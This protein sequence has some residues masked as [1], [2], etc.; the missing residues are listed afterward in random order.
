VKPQQQAAF[1][2]MCRRDPMF[3]RNNLIVD[4]PNGPDK[5]GKFMSP[6]QR[7]NFA[8]LD[9]AL[10][11]LT[12]IGPQPQI[13]RFWDQRS[14]GYSKT[15]D[16]AT[17]VLY[18]LT[19]CPKKLDAVVAAEDRDQALLIREQMLKV[20]QYNDWLYKYIDVQRNRIKNKTTDAT[21]N[22]LSRDTASSFGLT[23]ELVI[24]DEFTHWTQEDFWSS[25]FSSFNK[26]AARGGTLI[27]ACNAGWGTDWK[28]KV[29]ELARTSPLWHYSAPSGWAPWYRDID[30]DEQRAGLTASEFGRLWMNEWQASSGE[31]VTLEEADAC[32]NPMLVKL[33]KTPVDGHSFVASLDY[34]EKKDRCVGV[35]SDLY[36]GVIRIHRMD[37][38][39]PE[40]MPDKRVKA[41]WVYEWMKT[42]QQAFGGTNGNVTFILDPYQTLHFIQ[43][44]ETE[45][46]I[47]R[48]EFASGN[49]N[50]EMSVILR[51]L[52]TNRKV[53]WYPGC[54]QILDEHGRI[55][56]EEK[57]RDDLASELAKLV[58]KRI[59]TG[60]RWRFD[61]VSG[62]HDD[63]AFALG[64]VCRHIVL[65]SGGVDEWFVNQPTLPGVFQFS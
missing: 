20:L 41:S 11:H 35:V 46:D 19:F 18:A 36:D 58:T 52:I 47:E 43:Q 33:N 2:E 51:L 65:N 4:G 23:P 48:F 64:A 37:V 32:V 28:W 3:F 56:Q 17:N 21:L 62:E 9:P 16:Q 61:H 14:R 54:G 30:I 42:V 63:R 44:L 25:V 40:Q 5:F 60:K 7:K 12:G 13:Q 26:T 8:A 45:M 24:A 29:R 15:T 39:D 38:I 50:Y 59:G 10:K 6:L 22:S 57:G 49:G 34:A 31:F 53:Q 1:E 55:W 27:V